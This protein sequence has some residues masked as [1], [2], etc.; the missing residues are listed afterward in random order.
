MMHKEP[1]NEESLWRPSPPG[2]YKLAGTVLTVPMNALQHTLTVFGKTALRRIES[3]CFW[4]GT[5]MND[6][7][8]TVQ[9][10]VIP[11]QRNSWGNYFVSATAVAEMAAVTRPRGWVNL[12]Q[13]HTHPGRGIEHSRYDDEHANSRRALSVIFPFYGQ[14]RG[15]WPVGVG[16][17]EFQ[18]NYWYLLSEAD[19]A[20]RVALVNTG[21][22]EFLDL[23]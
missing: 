17:H 18:D 2:S 11:K 1:E 12:S 5:R 22:A 8:G 3:C 10:V 15:S 20:S 16:I 6:G 19:S 14:W 4:Y 7:S 13:I 21:D 23:R 9:A